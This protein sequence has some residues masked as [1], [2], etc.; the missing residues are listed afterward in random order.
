VPE[1][2]WQNRRWPDLSWDDA[3]LAGSLA[4][5]RLAQGR[6]LGAAGI[7]DPTLTTEAVAA[8]LIG[9]G[10]ATSAIEGERLDVEAVRS[11]VARHLGLPAAGRSTPQRSVDGLVEVLLDAT[12]GHRAPL[13][14]ERLC[15][16]QAALFPTGQSGLRRIRAGTLRGPDPMR[17]VSQRGGREH[18]HF[19]APP[20][21]RLERELRR[22]LSWF[23]DPPSG[24]DGLVRSGLAHLWFLTL[25]PFEDGNGRIARALTDMALAQDERRPE[26]F[27]SL[28]TRIERERA[29]YYDILE[30][31]QRGG[32]DVTP[33][34]SWFLAQIAAAC[35]TAETT[36]SRVLTKARFWLRFQGAS[37]ND[38]QRKVLNRLLDAGPGGFEGGITTRKYSGL[39]RVSRA[40]AYRELADLVEQGCLE[41]AGGGGRSHAYE[42]RWDG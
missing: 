28:S 34:L 14:L 21:D 35:E 3:A 1:W 19:L 4:Q 32:L 27:F 22:L 37:L 9:E 39:A 40:T 10:L 11:S 38:R 18:V 31:T 42:I 7:L 5:A 23:A 13:T 29:S 17:V 15:R 6:V 26:R 36:V 30:R 20:R 16:W 24:L 25:H 33:W 8:V 41:P 2:I 12:R